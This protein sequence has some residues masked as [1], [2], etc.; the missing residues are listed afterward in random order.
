M[1]EGLNIGDSNVSV[2]GTLFG[3]TGT[4]DMPVRPDLGNIIIP[5]NRAVVEIEIEPSGR[6]RNSNI[7][8]GMIDLP[9]SI[10]ESPTSYP[11]L[12]S[13]PMRKVKT[14]INWR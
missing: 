11:Y 3:T 14:P 9:G 4:I 5:G 2:I 10:L 7:L 8:P 13:E 1:A 6:I 12:E